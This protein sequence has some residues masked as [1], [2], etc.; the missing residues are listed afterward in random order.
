MIALH[1]L[2][3]DMAEKAGLC[4][5]GTVSDICKQ[6]GVNRTQVYE[7]KAQLTKAFDKIELPE[8]GRSPVKADP[9]SGQD[10][11]GWALQVT[12]L[13]YRLNHPGAFVRHPGGRTGY[14]P[15]FRR[16]IL[17]LLDD[18]TG[19]QERF[20]ALVE[21]PYP[22]LE[23]WKTR[24]LNQPYEPVPARP[25][26]E[27]GRK[28]SDV[29]R[30]IIEDYAA[31]QGSLRDFL[32]HE[33]GRVN[34][35]PNQIRRVLEIS[36]MISLR[37]RKS[38]RY[39]GSTQSVQPGTILVTDGKAVSVHLTTSKETR[40][41]NWQGMVDQT[42]ACHTAA[43]VTETENAQGVCR[44]YEQS[45]RFM[46]RK[47]EA[48]V[49]DNKPIHEDRLLKGTIEPE[50]TMI[51]ATLRRPENKAVIEGEFGKFEQAVGRIDLDDSSTESMAKSAIEEIIRA[52]TA[53]IN[54]AG[55]YEFEGLSR[56]QVLRRACPDP[57]KDRAFLEKLKARHDVYKKPDQ[58]PTMNVA[59]RILDE[60]FADF[61]LDPFDPQGTLRTWLSS[62][63]TPEAIRQGL[64]IF[65]TQRAKG[66][67]HSD[68]AH[69]Y[70]VKVIQNCQDE[71][72]LRQQEDQL[73]K[74]ADIEK[75]GFLRELD[76]EYELLK[77]DCEGRTGPTNDLAFQLSEKAVFGAM[78]LQRSFWEAKLKKL[79]ME[80]KDRIASV[81]RHIRR[82]FEA[83]WNDRFQLIN[84]LI[85]WNMGLTT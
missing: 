85:S 40:D 27:L 7:K 67:L 26:P 53:G 55:R 58:L 12:V 81:I 14:S 70:L 74:Y 8:P 64:A 20:C 82:L 63:Y 36:K 28:A 42:T 25:V 41:Y 23:T 61:D 9:V 62:R 46:G 69:R 24:D 57:E 13:Q 66:R 3:R 6:A 59:R 45:V 51:P 76:Q 44:A 37:N 60:G 31:W 15:G 16:I 21:V 47:P 17:D 83:H 84:H 5:E 50:T 49:H 56:F 34:L 54:H 33:P 79:L 29:A 43:V 80:R 18:W 71:I 73:R 19:S 77:A 35:P 10:N 78:I 2:T 39:R 11:A 52:Y 38:P 30:M 32:H 65:G 22:T 4:L 68:T 75:R 48:M 72:D 1:L